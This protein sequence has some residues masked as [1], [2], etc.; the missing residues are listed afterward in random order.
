MNKT[1]NKNNTTE[2]RCN[3]S[4]KVHFSMREREREIKKKSIEHK[5]SVQ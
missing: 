3:F 4:S 1:Q 5:K 2:Q